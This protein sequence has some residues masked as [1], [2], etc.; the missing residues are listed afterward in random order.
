MNMPKQT[1]IMRIIDL[2][3][4]PD[5]LNRFEAE[6]FGDHC[7]N[8]TVAKIRESFG[9]KLRQQWEIVPTRYNPSGVRVLRYWLED[10]K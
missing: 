10:V 9:A 4:R 8:S 6:R 2:L 5:G 1:K 7:L 3:K